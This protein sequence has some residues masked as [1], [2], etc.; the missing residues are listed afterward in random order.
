MRQPKQNGGVSGDGFL[1][2]MGKHKAMSDNCWP[3]Q[4]VVP[5]VRCAGTVSTNGL[6]LS[7]VSRRQDT[8]LGDIPS[9]HETLNAYW[10]TVGPASYM[11][12]MIRYSM[13][14]EINKFKSYNVI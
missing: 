1:H 9:K 13:G 6:I 2:C 14:I 4:A 5:P 3:D 7:L 8:L 10:F 12:K 11:N